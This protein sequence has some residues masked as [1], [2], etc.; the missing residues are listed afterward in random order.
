[1]TLTEKFIIEKRHFNT[2]DY[3]R[4]MTKVPSLM[5]GLIIFMLESKVEKITVSGVG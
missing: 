2:G 1:M 3:D 4:L 5:F